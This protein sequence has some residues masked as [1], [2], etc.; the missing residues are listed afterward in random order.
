[1][2]RG[3]LLFHLH[4][5]QLGQMSSAHQ[6]LFWR[7]CKIFPSIVYS[8]SQGLLLK[9]TKFCFRCNRNLH[10]LLILEDVFPLKS[11]AADRKF[12][13][14]TVFT[15]L[16]EF[17]F[18]WSPFIHKYLIEIM[19]PTFFFDICCYWSATLKAKSK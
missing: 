16:S 17:Q 11:V 5:G 12:P 18:K 13:D 2:S 14:G 1:M 9:I 8:W 10:K 7:T 3:Y 4:K 15:N 6:R 19:K